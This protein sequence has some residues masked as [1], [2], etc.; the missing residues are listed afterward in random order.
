MGVFD[1]K[2]HKKEQII[3]PKSYK[4]VIPEFKDVKSENMRNKEI[5]YFV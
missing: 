1:E 5:L 4:K 2:S 3:K